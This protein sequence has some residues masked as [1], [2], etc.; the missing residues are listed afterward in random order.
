MD[1]SMRLIH[2]EKE[3]RLKKVHKAMD[4]NDEPTI[5]SY[6]QTII[7]DFDLQE[8]LREIRKE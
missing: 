4:N 2:A 3:K 5:I 1:M 6:V 7:P 8:L